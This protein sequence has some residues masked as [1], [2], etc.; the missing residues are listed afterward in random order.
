MP[1]YP[2]QDSSPRR[3]RIL[4]HRRQREHQRGQ[5]QN[6]TNRPAP[7]STATTAFT[8][9]VLRSFAVRDPGNLYQ[10]IWHTRDAAGR[11][12]RW[13]DYEAIRERR[14]SGCRAVSLAV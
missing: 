12:L 13:R 8:L 3:P 6:P 14:E 9:D 11:G 2:G 1:A 5:R 10:V 4:V 7:L